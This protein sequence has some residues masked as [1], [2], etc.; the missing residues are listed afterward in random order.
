M[1]RLMILLLAAGF[2]MTAQAGPITYQ[3]QLQN[4]GQ[5]YSGSPGMAFRLFDDPNNGTQVGDTIFFTA[6]AV[7]D[8]LFQVE[9]DFGAGAFDGEQRYVEVEVAG[10]TLTPRQKITGSPWSHQALSVM[11]VIQKQMPDPG[12]PGTVWM[13]VGEAGDKIWQHGL[14]SDQVRSVF[15]RNGV[16]YSGSDDNTVRAADASDGDQ[17]WQHTLHLGPVQ[18]VFE[19]NGVVYSGSN[20][21]TLIAA[22]ARNG[23]LLWRLSLHSGAVY[24]VFKRNGVVYSGS[25]VGTVI[26]ANDAPAIHVSDGNQWWRQGWLQPMSSD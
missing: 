18:S 21:N 3:G 17:I 15:E 7:E 26:A 1:Y 14:H 6:V 10:E 13:R 23:S 4:E 24:S 9:L 5:P 22:D 2:A 12:N 16:V 8:G 11:P 20:D 25:W 19:R